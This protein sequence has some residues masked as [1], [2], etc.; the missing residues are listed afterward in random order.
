MLRI[1]FVPLRAGQFWPVTAI[2]CHR[3]PVPCSTLFHGS[4]TLN[5]VAN[6]SRRQ[7]GSV[8]KLPSGRYRARYRYDGD[9]LSAARTF[10]T[11]ADANAWLA[12]PRLTSGGAPGSTRN[13]ARKACSPMPKAGSKLGATSARRRG[14]STSIY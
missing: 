12:G 8:E 4:A 3:L 2:W 1:E 5:S 11:R 14:P 9:W 13:R 10:T 7:F 6:R